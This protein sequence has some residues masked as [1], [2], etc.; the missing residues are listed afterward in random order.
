VSQEESIVSTTAKA[1]VLWFN[2]AKGYGLVQAED[3]EIE[4]IRVELSSLTDK[5]TIPARG[6]KVEVVFKEEPI[7]L[8]AEQVSIVASASDSEEHLQ[9]P[10]P[11]V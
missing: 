9:D 5:K 2:E 6:D 3:P 1:K 11:G 4:D 10:E 7:G 8:V